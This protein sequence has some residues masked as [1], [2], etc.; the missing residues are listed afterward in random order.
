MKLMFDAAGRVIQRSSS[1]GSV[2]RNYYDGNGKKMT[3]TSTFEAQKYLIRSSLLGGGSSLKSGRI[4]K[5]I[6]PT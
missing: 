6:V 4:G 3:S 2:V 5:S 1:S